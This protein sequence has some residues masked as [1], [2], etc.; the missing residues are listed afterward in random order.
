MFYDLKKRT[1]KLNTI[2]DGT[3]NL[4][5]KAELKEF[6]REEKKLLASQRIP[7][8]RSKALDTAQTYLNSLDMPIEEFDLNTDH[9]YEGN[10]FLLPM[11]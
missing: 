1:E 6:I 5:K 9:D 7:L 10:S 2:I 8:N 3:D 4:T 11:C